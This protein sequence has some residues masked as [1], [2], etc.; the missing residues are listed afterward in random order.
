MQ[1]AV[2]LREVLLPYYLASWGR[3]TVR[4]RSRTNPPGHPY[5]SSRAARPPIV[6]QNSRPQAETSTRG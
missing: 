1:W 6:A 5:S 2:E 4:R 3:G